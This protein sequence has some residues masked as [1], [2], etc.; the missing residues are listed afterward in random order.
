MIFL[1]LAFVT[2]CSLVKKWP[3]AAKGLKKRPELLKQKFL[4][5]PILIAYM[6]VQAV[7]GELGLW[8]QSEVLGSFRKTLLGFFLLPEM[9]IH[10]VH[11]FII[12]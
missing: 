5:H 9:E 2:K 11:V 7:I 6:N 3:N 4:T 8:C 1:L 10:L 12:L